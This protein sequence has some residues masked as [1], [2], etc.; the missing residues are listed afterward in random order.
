MLLPKISSNYFITLTFKHNYNDCH[1]IKT[2]CKKTNP[3]S[4]HL[5]RETRAAATSGAAQEEGRARVLASMATASTKRDPV[6]EVTDVVDEAW[7]RGDP[8]PGASPPRTVVHWCPRPWAVALG[9]APR[10]GVAI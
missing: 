3:D 4:V 10:G 6:R 5:F 2:V 8:V 7:R 1:R 9:P